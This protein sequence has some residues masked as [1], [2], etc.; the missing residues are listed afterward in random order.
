MIYYCDGTQYVT[1]FSFYCG[2]HM[3]V[4]LRILYDLYNEGIKVLIRLFSSIRN[5]QTKRTDSWNYPHMTTVIP[6][7]R[8][9]PTDS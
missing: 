8:F 1:F 5:T 3:F 7:A 4:K 2:R 9:G 6:A